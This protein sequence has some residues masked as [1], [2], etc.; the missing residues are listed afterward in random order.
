VRKHARATRVEVTLQ[1]EPGGLTATI[2]DDGVGFDAAS[3]ALD[4]ARPGGLMF[5]RE[6][7]EVAGGR[8]RIESARGRGTTVELRLP[9]T[10]GSESGLSA[11]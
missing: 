1:Q 4:D 8:F 6:R 3:A 5:A 9:A 11:A 7:V 2:A 10:S